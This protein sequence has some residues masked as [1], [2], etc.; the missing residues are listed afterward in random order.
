MP[1]VRIVGKLCQSPFDFGQET[2]VLFRDAILVR[3]LDV[4]AMLQAVGGLGILPDFHLCTAV[5]LLLLLLSATSRVA[6][7]FGTVNC[8]RLW[9]RV[10]NCCVDVVDSLGCAAGYLSCGRIP[11]MQ[12]AIFIK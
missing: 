7:L 4:E 12:P 2:S 1:V 10:V 3:E 8:C 6:P 11:E 9:S 5:L